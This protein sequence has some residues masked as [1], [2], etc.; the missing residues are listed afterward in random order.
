MYTFVSMSIYVH[1]ASIKHA[2]GALH[3]SFRK[4]KIVDVFKVYEMHTGLGRQECE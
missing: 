4:K 1:I 2:S 3:V